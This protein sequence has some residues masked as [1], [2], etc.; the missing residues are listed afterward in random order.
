MEHVVFF[1]APDGTPAFRRLASLD[2]S[3]RLVEHLRNVEG[4]EQVSVHALNEVPLTFRAYYRVEVPSALD[5]PRELTAEAPKV[6][7]PLQ[8]VPT[9]EPVAVAEVAPEP[10]P[11]LALALV[12]DLPVDDLPVD[13]KV[14]EPASYAEEPA[15]EYVPEPALA[16][17]HG[18]GGSASL[19]FFA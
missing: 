2:E 16:S 11:V 15:P 14:A 18:R 8:A 17:V 1:P 4:V 3:V 5:A 6:E 9:V 13:P 10:V 12:G 19:G 7:V